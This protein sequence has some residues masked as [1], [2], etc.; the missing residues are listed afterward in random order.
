MTATFA[1]AGFSTAACVYNG[2]SHHWSAQQSYGSSGGNGGPQRQ[3][4]TVAE[5]IADL[6]R[7]RTDAL[8]QELNSL[9]PTRE[10]YQ[11]VI[12]RLGE[13][14]Q[15]E[16]PASRLAAQEAETYR[17]MDLEAQEQVEVLQRK[18]EEWENPTTEQIIAALTGARLE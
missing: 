8:A 13:A 14:A 9:S 18:L 17:Q 10:V 4:R 11:G 6:K 7:E 2:A 15:G 3:E 1:F 12:A 5:V 16:G